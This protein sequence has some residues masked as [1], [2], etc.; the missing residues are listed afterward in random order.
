M[1]TPFC[2]QVGSGCQV[3]VTVV[4]V[5]V[6]ILNSGAPAGTEEKSTG[7]QRH[8]RQVRVTSPPS[9]HVRM[10][11]YCLCVTLEADEVCM[12]MSI[13]QKVLLCACVYAHQMRIAQ[14]VQP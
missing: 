12:S 9:T 3:I 2:S 5:T 8:N 1:M 14:L 13:K 7:E 6:V 10:F 11:L 4:A